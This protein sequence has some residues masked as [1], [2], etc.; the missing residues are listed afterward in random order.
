[1]WH[2]VLYY[3]NIYVLECL[4]SLM[5]VLLHCHTVDE[6]A[7]GALLLCYGIIRSFRCGKHAFDFK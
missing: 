2:R 6:D 4:Y 5:R 1:M 3:I 7:D